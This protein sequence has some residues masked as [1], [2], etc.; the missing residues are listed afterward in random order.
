MITWTRTRKY[1]QADRQKEGPKKKQ[2]RSNQRKASKQTNKQKRK[3][4]KKQMIIIN[5][6]FKFLLSNLIMP[7]NYIYIY[8]CI[9]IRVFSG[10]QTKSLALKVNKLLKL[11]LF[12]LSLFLPLFTFFYR[13]F[14]KVTVQFDTQQIIVQTNNN[15]LTQYVIGFCSRSACW[16]YSQLWYCIT[17]FYQ[18]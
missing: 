8:I 11:I 16:Q 3:P 14:E 15:N 10:V 7:F 4:M 12:I 6:D 17:T 5:I 13:A 9:Y 18:F 2:S 1:K